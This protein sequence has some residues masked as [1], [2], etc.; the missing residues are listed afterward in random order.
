MP[1]LASI[2]TILDVDVIRGVSAT[3]AALDLVIEI[4]HGATRTEDFTSL[5]ARLTSP[6]PDNLVDF[7]HV[8]TDA[9]A[10]ELAIATARRFVEAEPTRAVAIL[11]CRIPRTFIDCN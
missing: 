11:R 7:F 9:G 8:N 4:P 6:L 5:A 2:P 1:A 3:G 10:P